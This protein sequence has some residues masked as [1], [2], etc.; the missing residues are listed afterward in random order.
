MHRPIL[1]FL[2]MDDLTGYVTYDH[3]PARILEDRGWAVE[4]PSWRASEDWARFAAVVIRSPWDYQKD[5]DAYMGVLRQIVAA[6]T[7][8]HNSLGIVEWNLRKTYLREL[9]AKGVST[10]PT[11]WEDRLQPG[12]L[13]ELGRRL[14]AEE[15]VLKPIVGANA[16]GAFRLRAP[17][18]GPDARAAE[19]MY[20]SEPFMA[21]PFLPSVVE[22]GEIS[23]FFFCG[24]YSHAVHKKPKAGD[25]RVQE[26]H[27][28]I[29]TP[30][31]AD[32]AAQAVSA[33]ALR[34]LPGPTL[35]ARIDLVRLPDG[36]WAV[37]EVEVNEPSLYFN[38]DPESAVRFADAVESVVSKSR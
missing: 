14:N 20:A 30:V 16:D 29:L 7:P 35:Y 34:S 12:G 22:D 5:P 1:A 38:I 9:T 32:S 10:I 21:Q 4:F 31:V 33:E 36:A 8:L 19:R 25:F 3:L 2:S 24:A 13:P 26:E 15:I 17:F 37:M 28:G 23:L 27:G 18:A 6:G 11:L